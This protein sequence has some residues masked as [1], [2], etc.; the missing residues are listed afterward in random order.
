VQANDVLLNITG[1][2]VARVCRAPAR[3]NQQVSIIRPKPDLLHPVFFGNALGA[4]FAKGQATC[5]QRVR[6]D[7]EAI[8]KAQIEEYE[9]MLPPVDLQRKFAASIAEIDRLKA[10]HRAHLK[11]LDALFA[12]LQNRSF[13]A[14]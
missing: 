7:S 4:S 13:G 1:A 12:S 14:N 10:A 6:S 5:Y 11:K 3:V 8:T 9:V 2:S